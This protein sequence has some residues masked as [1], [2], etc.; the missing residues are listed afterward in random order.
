MSK[1]CMTNLN[2]NL[3]LDPEILKIVKKNKKT[4]VPQNELQKYVL[5]LNHYDYKKI[6]KIKG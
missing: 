2:S 3:Q 1:K 6:M 5:S 4:F